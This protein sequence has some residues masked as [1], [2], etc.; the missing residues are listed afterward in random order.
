MMEKE[1]Y[2][3]KQNI[4]S[5]AEKIKQAAT[6]RRENQI[7]AFSA[8]DAILLVTDMQQFFLNPKSHAFVPSAEAILPNIQKLISCS[9]NNA[10][11]VIFSRHVNDPS[12]AALM[13]SWYRDL[14]SEA[15]GQ[16]GIVKEMHTK[17]H[18]I[19]DKPQYDAFY[20]TELLQIFRDAEKSQ[21]IICGVMTNLCVETTARSAFV[22]GIQP[23]VPIDATACY[24]YDMHL[25]SILNLAQGFTHPVLT[26]DILEKCKA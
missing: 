26:N 24:H 7:H 25:G 1:R 2:F 15:S 18:L 20:E 13:G 8:K 21:I 11:P 3:T 19:I 6:I 10:I 12:N 4:F 14:L 23:F 22:Q 16:A 9:E 17:Q 5:V